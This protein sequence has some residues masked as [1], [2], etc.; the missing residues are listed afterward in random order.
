MKSKTT[1]RS[2]SHN[3]SR[4]HGHAERAAAARE[5]YRREK[6]RRARRPLPQSEILEAAKREYLALLE[7]EAAKGKGG[8]PKKKPAARTDEE[9]EASAE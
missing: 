1:S 5:H 8:R 6:A 9:D 3:G 4:H 2:H 7:A